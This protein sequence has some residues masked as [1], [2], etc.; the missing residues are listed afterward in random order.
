LFESRHHSE[1]FVIRIELGLRFCGRDISDRLEQAAVVEPVDPF[2]NCKLDGLQAT[3][4]VAP[5]DHFGLEEA[6]RRRIAEAASWKTPSRTVVA[7]TS[8][9]PVTAIIG[10]DQPRARQSVL[11][12]R[13]NGRP[14][15]HL[16]RG[17]FHVCRSCYGRCSQPNNG[18]H[19]EKGH[20]AGIGDPIAPAQEG[21]SLPPPPKGPAREAGSSLPKAR[22]GDLRAWLFLAWP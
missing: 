5:V 15:H 19:Q 6:D 14:L 9:R 7:R 21:V 4:W 8:W 13:G 18:Q 17:Q 22:R 3:P 20:Q 10:S 16:C 2:E 11:Q 12:L 1:L